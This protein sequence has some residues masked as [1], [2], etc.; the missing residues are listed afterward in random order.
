MLTKVALS[1]A[2]AAV[3]TGFGQAQQSQTAGVAPS[4]QAMTL[5]SLPPAASTVTNWYKQNV[6]DP[7]EE[8]IGEISDVLISKDG[9]IAAFILS[10][11]G[12]L[13]LGGKHVAV[14]FDSVHAAQ[15]KHEWWLTM[16]T[17]KEALKNATGYKYDHTKST[18]LPS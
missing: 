18:W 10:V 15:G 11:S 9:K 2:I 4:E 7:S 17:T 5:K 1:L 13:G 16:N 3:L 8:K 6:Y 12:F 14:P